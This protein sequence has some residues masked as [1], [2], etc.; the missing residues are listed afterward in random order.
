MELDVYMLSRLQFAL[1]IMFHYL[2]PPLTI[3]LSWLMVIMEGM[4]LKTGDREYEAIAR[5]WTELFAVV[6]AMGVATGIVMEFQFGT[7]WA[8]Y[9]RYVGDVFGSPLAAEGIFAFFLE[10]SFLAVLVFGWDRVSARMHFFSTCMVSFGAMLSSIWIVVA[11]SWQQT[12]AGFVVNETLGRAEITSF[13]AMVFNPSTVHRVMHVWLGAGILGAFFVLSI[14]SYYLLH[15]RHTR[16]ARKMFKVALAVGT[17]MSLAALGSG[18]LQA[19]NVGAT[20]PAKLAAFE[21]LYKTPAEGEGAPLYLFGLP[22]DET[23]SVDFGFA[24][25]GGLSFLMYESFKTPVTGLDQFPREDWPPVNLSFQAYHMMLTVGV[26]FIGITL[27]ACFFWWRGT[28]FD[29]RWLL[30]VFVFA[31]IGPFIG[32]EAGW[33][34][35]EIGR[36]PWIVYGLLR[37][38]E[39]F[40]PAVSAGQVVFSI[41]MFLALYTFMFLVWIFIMS[42]KI[43]KGPELREAASGA[44]SGALNGADKSEEG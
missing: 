18:H 16:M 25:P 9:S 12:P 21:G 19:K 27:L 28:V 35:A 23:E 4:H 32:N 38:G 24:V 26:F 40:S 20:Q 10:S 2:F 37:T 11:N 29:Q 7:N 31:V 43:Q 34:A 33:C 14:S 44:Y 8:T 1:T 3:G 17:F 41:G 39:A 36:Q 30:W 42:K 6:F 5:F 15:G 22:N 13:R